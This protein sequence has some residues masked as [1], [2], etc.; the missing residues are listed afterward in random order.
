[1]IENRTLVIPGSVNI[2][3][4]WAEDPDGHFGGPLLSLVA[5]H[6]PTGP[7]QVAMTS[8]LASIFRVKEG[9]LWTEDGHARRVVGIVQN[10]QSLL[11]EFALLAPGQISGPTQVTVLFDARGAIPASLGSKESIQNVSSARPHN[12]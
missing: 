4:L 5:G 1:M 11:D 8:R 2:Y 7:G 12:G 3:D 10:P 9:G 6:Y